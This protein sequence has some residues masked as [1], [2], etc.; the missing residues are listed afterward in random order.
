MHAARLAASP[1]LL[2][3]L[4]ALQA[5]GRPLTTRE[6]MRRARICAV[7][8][9]VAELRENGAD[10]HCEQRVLP[11]GTRR[12]FYTLIRTPEGWRG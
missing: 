6:L 5:A 3:A 4:R 10:I 12:W 9:V 11:D 1:R 7:N 2:R 8:A